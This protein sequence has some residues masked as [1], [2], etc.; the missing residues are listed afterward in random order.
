MLI[1]ST[2]GLLLS[3]VFIVD[4]KCKEETENKPDIILISNLP[5]LI[6]FSA[7]IARERLISDLFV[8]YNPS[9][10]PAAKGERIDVDVN[11]ELQHFDFRESDGGFNLVGFFNAVRAL[12][13]QL[14]TDV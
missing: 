3:C 2:I 7:A 8:N 4:A 1:Y 9:V 5:W 11:L 6:V 13:V 10:R 12:E 14:C